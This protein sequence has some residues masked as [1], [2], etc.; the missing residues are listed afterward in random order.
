MSM[1]SVPPIRHTYA[2]QLRASKKIP[3]LR[4]SFS[5]HRDTSRRF[6][7]SPQ[8]IQSVT[9]ELP[10]NAVAL[11]RGRRFSWSRLPF[12][13]SVPLSRAIEFVSQVASSTK[14]PS[15]QPRHVR[16]L[17]PFKFEAAYARDQSAGPV[18]PSA[19]TTGL[20]GR[21]T[22]RWHFFARKY[23]TLAEFAKALGT[24]ELN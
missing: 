4:S 7:V 10:R 11:S 6:I 19:L 20:R 1:V 8:I 13:P 5:W 3:I 18:F 2:G 9:A 15:I 16:R 22:V 12:V 24:V 17:F 21:A 14:K 23:Y